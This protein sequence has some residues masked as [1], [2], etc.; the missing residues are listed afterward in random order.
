MRSAFNDLPL[1]KNHDTIRIAHGRKTVRDNK[2][3]TVLHQAL[4]TVV[5]V[6]LRSRID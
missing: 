6:H 1:L 5:N 4:H 3:R 2:C